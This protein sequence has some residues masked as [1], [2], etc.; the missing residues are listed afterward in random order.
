MGFL[1]CPFKSLTNFKYFFSKLKNKNNLK[2]KR[3]RIHYLIFK[4]YLFVVKIGKRR[5]EKDR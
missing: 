1:I 5:G 4:I 2:K 3:N